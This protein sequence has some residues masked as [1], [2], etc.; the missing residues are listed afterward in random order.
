MKSGLKYFFC[1]TDLPPSLGGYDCVTTN[2]CTSEN[3]SAGQLYHPYIDKDHF[4]Q[5]DMSGR[6][7]V[8]P[9]GP[10]TK[11]NQAILTCA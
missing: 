2:P 11:W 10:G 7:F 3:L 8:M 1:I 4:V 6:C 5:C 9:C